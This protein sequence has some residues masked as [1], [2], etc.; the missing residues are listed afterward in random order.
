[1]TKNKICFLLVFIFG[2]SSFFYSLFA[3]YYQNI[4]PCPLCLLQRLTVFIITIFSLIFMLHNPKNL[5]IKVYS[6]IIISF[7]LFGIKVA[8]QHLHLISLPE[9][10]QPQS[11]GLPLNIVFNK[12]PF[13]KFINYI[14]QGDAECSKINWTIFGIIAPQA[15]LI[16]CTIFI[17][18]MLL[19]IFSKIKNKHNY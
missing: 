16:L 19:V 4:E 18:L 15:F 10:Q 17:L 12:L 2:A 7:S 11:C 9:N 8:Y 6:L 13:L 3:Q 1:M 5:L 14:L